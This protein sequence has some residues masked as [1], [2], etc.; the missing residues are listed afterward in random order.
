M[1][2]PASIRLD[3]RANKLKKELPR[4]CGS[5]FFVGRIHIGQTLISARKRLI[6]FSIR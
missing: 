1:I 6:L 2:P 4:N 5:S 3:K